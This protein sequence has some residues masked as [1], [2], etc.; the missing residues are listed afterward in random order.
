MDERRYVRPSGA[1]RVFNGIVGILGRLGVSLAGSRTLA[2]RGRTSGEWRTTPV[3]PLT[4]DGRR[5]LV[6]PRGETQWVR[7]IRAAGGGELRRGRHVE[8]ITVTEVPDDAKPPVIAAYLEKWGWEVGRF[9]E[10]LSADS[11]PDEI[12]AA[13]PGF[14]VFLID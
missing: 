6:A 11:G 8:A 4:V 5:Y 7:N 10:G 3:N 9:F 2:V 1:D 14:P 13:A 12:R